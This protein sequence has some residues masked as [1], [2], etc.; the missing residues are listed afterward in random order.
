[1][2]NQLIPILCKYQKTKQILRTICA[3]GGATELGHGTGTVR[4]VIV[5]VEGF[6]L[7]V[8]FVLRY[9]SEGL[10]T[11]QMCVVYS[12]K[13]LS[14]VNCMIQVDTSTCKLRSMAF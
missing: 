4:S 1:M 9:D 14:R 10:L 12:H 2:I 13:S 3:G 5:K 11:M 7:K 6:V 8:L